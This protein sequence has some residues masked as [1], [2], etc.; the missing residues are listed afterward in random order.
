M[1]LKSG[2][3][4]SQDALL[5]ISR[6]LVPDLL[7]TLTILFDMNDDEGQQNQRNPLYKHFLVDKPVPSRAKAQ[8]LLS[9]ASS[10]LEHFARLLQIG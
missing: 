2:M 6:I 3:P 1:Y 4:M 5:L 10:P 8:I 7:H 9:V